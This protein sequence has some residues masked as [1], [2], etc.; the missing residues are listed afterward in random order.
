MAQHELA[1]TLAELPKILKRLQAQKLP[2]RSPVRIIW[3]DEE[4]QET[5]TSTGHADIDQL[6]ADLEK[7]EGLSPAAQEE[8]DQNRQVFQETFHL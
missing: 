5:V 2:R 1:T 6:F 7:M 8:F 3:E 4:V